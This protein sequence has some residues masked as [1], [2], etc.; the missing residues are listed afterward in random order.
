MEE[1]ENIIKSPYISL[2]KYGIPYYGPFNGIKYLT[3][4]WVPRVEF[5]DEENNIEEYTRIAYGSKSTRRF[6]KKN[7]EFT[8][9]YGIVDRVECYESAINNDGNVNYKGEVLFRK[10]SRNRE[11]LLCEACFQIASRQILEKFHL[12]ESI[13]DIKDI[14]CYEDESIGF[15]MIPFKNM[16]FLSDIL[17]AINEEQI[18]TCITK[19][20]FILYILSQE[21]GI[22]HRDLKGNNILISQLY[23]SSP[24]FGSINYVNTSAKTLM[25]YNG[26]SLNIMKYPNV[27]FV[28]FGFSCSGNGSSTEISATNY[29]PMTDPCPKEGR[30]LFLLL[31]HIYITI[32][33]RKEPIVKYIEEL[34]EVPG[35][36]YPQFVRQHGEERLDWVYFL[37][38]SSTF[39]A[40]KCE[41]LNIL[42]YLSKYYP[43]IIDL[44]ISK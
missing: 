35:K 22:N 25:K 23:N 26:I 36:N 17:N 4:A 15:T 2:F 27:H 33:T 31:T 41:P 28:D 38:G 29:F 39:K 44:K 32:H 8:G 42:I 14:V 5:V 30:D 21:L 16:N 43:H 10:K 34:L 1:E 3:T 12:E 40:P 37:L 18:V 7:H 9:S 19:I 24:L 11:S 6:I 13:S 20:S